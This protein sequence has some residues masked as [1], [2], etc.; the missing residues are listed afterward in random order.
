MN[1]QTLCRASPASFA[2]AISG[3][4]LKYAR[5]WRMIDKKLLGI[6]NG[7]VTRLVINVPPQFGKSELV[8]KHFPAWYLGEYPDRK[9]I[10]VSYEAEYAASWGMRARELFREYGPQVWGSRLSDLKAT[11]DWWETT[12]GGYMAT[13]GAM[14]SI[15]GKGA[16]LL[17]IDDPHKN[18][19][20]A[21]SKTIRDKI[22]DNFTST[23]L[24]RLQPKSAVILIQTRWHEDDLTGKL[25]RLEGDKWDKVIL[26]ALDDKE[27]S[28]FP[29]RFSAEELMSR[30]KTM[31]SYMFDALYQQ[32][33]RPREG[34]MFKSAWLKYYQRLPE[35]FDR[36]IQ[37]WDLTFGD[38]GESYVV[39]MVL[40]RSGA[41]T[42]LID[43]ARDKWAFP[44]QV[45]QIRLMTAKH[46]YATA[47]LIEK[48]AN[49]QATIDTLRSE[50]PG[51]IAINPTE[52]KEARA[53]AISYIV[54]AGNFFIPE[55]ASYKDVL[56]EELLSFPNGTTDDMV[57]T[58]SQGLNEL[59]NGAEVTF[60]KVEWI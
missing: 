48:K 17:I 3:S 54:E 18:A 20:E 32:S 50:I 8:S 52:S 51:I 28:L 19:S 42:Y 45:R 31:G 47:K 2:C 10:L 4:R 53:S 14:G 36:V 55:F 56:T 40:G 13:A 44:E 25:L 24:T 60:E 57:D 11:N 21:H 34:G 35:K 41:D 30:R 33:P 1:W 15:T 6:I 59:Y 7:K 27:E 9:V 49:G 29:D 16:H 26:P 23:F 43:M 12:A 22:W 38:T 37:S 58:I 5:H 39:G 46:P